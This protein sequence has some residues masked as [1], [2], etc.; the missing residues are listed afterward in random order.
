MMTANRFLTREPYGDESP[1]RT[2]FFREPAPLWISPVWALGTL[3]AKSVSAYGWPSR[4][5]DY[6][7][8]A[9]EDLAV[10]SVEDEGAMSTETLFSEDRILQFTEAGILPLAGILR[11][12]RAILPKEALLSGGSLKFQLFMN[13]VFGFLF[14]LRAD[15]GA[16]VDPAHLEAQLTD[17]L[18]DLFRRTGHEPPEDLSITA[19]PADT[20]DALRLSIA[21]TPPASVLPALERLAFSFLW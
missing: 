14:S 20:E 5:T 1:P 3:I 9:L 17:A 8:I 19:G 7:R 15:M 2:A 4:F 21:F 11:K 16:A 12:D 6:R 18:S 13:R 10:H